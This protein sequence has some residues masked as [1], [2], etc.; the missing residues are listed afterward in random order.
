MTDQANLATSVEALANAKVLC[1][2]DVMLDRFVYGDVDR[3]S[4]EAP[5]PV[6]S[7]KSDNLMLGGAGNVARNLSGLGA[8][9]HFIAVVGNDSAGKDVTKLIGKIDNTEANLITDPGRR[10]SIKTRYI[11]S[12]QQMMRAD[13][14]SIEAIEGA[15][16]ERVITL[17]KSA[18]KDCAAMVLADY[19]KGVLT[20]E[21]IQELIE[22][23]S[24]AKV[25]V[26]ID[27]QGIDYSRYHGAE[28][29]T[30]NQKELAEATAMAVGDDDEISAAARKLISEHKINSVLATRS[31]D[32]MSLIGADSFEHFS[33]EAREIFDVSGAGDTVAATIAAS[34]AAGVSLTD[35]VQLANTAAGIVV[36]KVG[37][38]VAYASDIIEALHRQ[39]FSS[40]EAKILSLNSAID[41]AEVWRSKGHKLGFTNGCFDL[42]H[43]GHISTIAKAKAACDRLIIGL[44]SDESVKRLKGDD[45]P[46][47][48]EAARAQVL[49]SL[50][51]VD[52]VVIFSEDTPA[53]IIE[54]IKPEVFV[55][56]ADYS[57][58]EIPEAAIVKAYGGKI[59]LAELED[60]HSTTATIAKLNK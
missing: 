25:P 58:D 2:G 57:V 40:S 56:G 47:Q 26:I 12:G 34:L 48:S 10:T 1:I 35:A 39:E 18:L 43:P 15:T 13:D 27:P 19:A 54:A 55:K 30:P 29:I 23:A 9:T 38:A 4:P 11:A 7:V 59:V 36:A 31:G 16:K 44:N 3:I 22:L 46:V 28:L 24:A 41:R 42:L 53:N 20:P 52:A 8:T 50:E 17:A 5:I 33:A 37:T 14:E 6:F 21:I 32:G 51:N 45:R 60:G 49:A